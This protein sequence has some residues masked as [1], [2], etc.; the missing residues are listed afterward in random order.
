MSAIKAK[1]VNSTTLLITERLAAKPKS[2]MNAR[3]KDQV[4]KMQ[5]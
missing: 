2:P 1:D 5:A 3:F 4:Q